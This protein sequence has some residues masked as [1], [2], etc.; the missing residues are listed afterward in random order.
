M[1]FMKNLVSPF[2]L[3]FPFTIPLVVR[4]L[5]ITLLLT[6][7]VL[8]CWSAITPVAHAASHAA[9]TARHTQHSA[10]GQQQPAVASQPGTPRHPTFSPDTSSSVNQL[11]LLPFYTYISQPLTGHIGLSINVANGNLV[12]QSTDLHI[13]GTGLALDVASY[14]NSLASTSTLCYLNTP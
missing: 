3:R 1:M 4:Y 6:G 7:F 13:S 9:T 2:H 11:G 12:V 8:G 5:L 10:G 14:Y